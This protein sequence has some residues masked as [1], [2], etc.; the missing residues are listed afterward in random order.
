MCKIIHELNSSIFVVSNE[1]LVSDKVLN[2]D[3][4]N[5]SSYVVINKNIDKFK[6][7]RLLQNKITEN[8]VCRVVCNTQYYDCIL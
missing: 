1:R 4:N 3:C 6:K 5:D 7:K 8:Y 2:Y